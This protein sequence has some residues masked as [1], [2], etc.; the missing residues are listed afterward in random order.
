MRITS[1]S[2]LPITNVQDSVIFL[3]AWKKEST[4]FEVVKYIHFNPV[5]HGFAQK[6]S[7]WRFSSFN[8][9]AARGIYP[10]DWSGCDSVDVT[11]A[12][13]DV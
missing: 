8:D 13:Y 6:P 7:E 9:Y 4:L 11:G 1:E 2:R 12:E 10:V 3:L 5:K